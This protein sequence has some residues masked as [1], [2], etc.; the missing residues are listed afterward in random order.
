MMRHFEDMRHTVEQLH[1]E[2]YRHVAAKIPNY[3][4]STY[5]MPSQQS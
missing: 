5:R 2:F 3:I 1:L 4:A